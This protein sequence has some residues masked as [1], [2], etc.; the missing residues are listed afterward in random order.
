MAKKPRD[1]KRNTRPAQLAAQ[2]APKDDPPSPR[3]LRLPRLSK[4]A[5]GP[6]ERAP[7][8]PHLASVRSNPTQSLVGAKTGVQTGPPRPVRVRI[9]R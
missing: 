7:E 6:G 2:T 4:A 5:P 1:Q 3:S 9:I 8:T